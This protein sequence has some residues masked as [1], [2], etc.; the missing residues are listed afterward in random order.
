MPDS[1]TPARKTRTVILPAAVRRSLSLQLLWLAALFVLLAVILVLIPSVS[2]RT[3]AWLGARTEAAYLVSMALEA[4]GAEILDPQVTSQLFSTADILGVTVLRDGANY[5]I[6]APDLE[7]RWDWDMY[8]IDLRER[9]EFAM[10]QA[11][12]S[13]IFSRGDYLVR[14]IGEPTFADGETADILVSGA[15]LRSMLASHLLDILF[16]AFI[17]S[18]LGAALIYFLLTRMIVRPVRR[19]TENMA[20]FQANP[21]DVAN[22]IKPGSREDEIGMAEQSLATLERRLHELLTQRTRLAALGAGVSKISHDL[23][24]ILAS[25]QLMSDRLAKSD[26]PRV[27]KLSPRLIQSLDRAITLSRDTLSYARMEPAA[28]NKTRFNLRELAAEVFDDTASM[29]VRFENTAPETLVVFAD[30]TQLYRTLFNLTRNAVEALSPPEGEE[31]A[32]APDEPAGRITLSADTSAQGVRIILQDNGPGVSE[33]AREALFEPFKGSLKPGGSG[34]GV[35]IAHEIVR[36]HGG[37]LRLADHGP[38]ARFEIT[39]PAS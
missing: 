32:D 10:A 30:R 35:A 12:W 21:D 7:D 26:D 13:T 5:L 25:A 29:H 28:L 38:G 17:A 37:S 15:T 19:L 31:G 4:P 20:A 16:F 9:D 36:A 39:L 24:N 14:V 2:H 8:T 34:L 23:R 33:T 22:I 1:E 3:Y 18:S 6:M 27:R 11:A